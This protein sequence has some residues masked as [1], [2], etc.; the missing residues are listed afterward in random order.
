[1][2]PSLFYQGV[3]F[4][5]LCAAYWWSS[6]HTEWCCK[7]LRHTSV[8]RIKSTCHN[9]FCSPGAV[10]AQCVVWHDPWLLDWTVHPASMLDGTTVPWLPCRQSAWV[11]G[12]IAAGFLK[13]YCGSS[14]MVHLRISAS[15]H[16]SIWMPH[17]VHSGLVGSLYCDAFSVTRLLSTDRELIPVGCKC[18]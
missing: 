7:Q 6:L 16:T 3:Q 4:C 1:V 13:T 11:T 8:V 9:C 10:F 17:V 14:M 18:P 12:R 5:K 15:Q 2:V